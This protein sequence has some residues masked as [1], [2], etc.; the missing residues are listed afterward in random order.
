MTDNFSIIALND[1]LKIILNQYK[2]NSSVFGIPQQ[3]FFIPDNNLTIGIKKFGRELETPIGIA[4]GPQSQL[5]QNIV[6]AWLCGA[7]FIELKTVQTLDELKVSKP[8]I[9]MQDEGYNCEWSQELKLHQSFD[10]YLN[11]WIIIHVLRD[12]FGWNNSKQEATIFNMSVGYDYN[13]ILEENIQWFFRKMNNATGELNEKIE[14]LKNIYPN[15]VNLKINP[16]ISNNITLSTMHG[17]PPEEIEKIG[18]YLIC[19]KKLHTSIKLNPTLLGKESL[20]KI[21]VN[22]GFETEVPDEAFEHDLKFKDAIKIIKRLQEKAN[23]KNLEFG[24]KLT[25]TLESRNNKKVFPSSEKMMYMSGR[26]LHPISIVLANKLQTEFD[27]NLNISFSGGADAFNIDNILNSGLMPVTVCTDLLKPG[28]YSRLKQYIDVI[29]TEYLFG[30]TKK[31]QLSFLNKYAETAKK[32]NNYKKTDLRNPSI[33]TNR[34]LEQFDCINA[35]CVDTC[36]TNQGIP[37]YLYYTSK[38]EFEKAMEIIEQTNPFPNTTGMVCDHLCQTKCTRINY[39]SPV[40]IREIKRFVSEKNRLSDARIQEK[41]NHKN[42]KSV[43]IIGAGPSGLSCANYLSN[44]G[45]KVDVFEEKDEVGGMVSAAIPSF[46]L[47]NEAMYIDINKIKEKGVK[48]HF[49][50]KITKKKFQQLREKND[51][52]YLAVGAQKSSSLNIDGINNNAVLDPLQFLFNVKKEKITNLGTNVIIIGGGNTAMDAARTAFRLVEKTGSVSIVY[53]RKI[54]QMPADLGEIEA[55]IEEGIKIYELSSPLKIEF[56]NNKLTGIICQKMKL[57]EKDESGR[58]KPIAIPNSE[59]TITA[60]TIIPAIGQELNI[61]FTKFEN[62]KT[63]ANSF[64]TKLENVF[65][66]GD[67]YRGAS[68]AINAIGD[69]RKVAQEI[70]NKAKINFKTKHEYQRF[71]QSKLQLMLQKFNRAKA[72][73]ITETSLDDRKNFN[74]VSTSL[75]EEQAIREASRCLMCDEICNICTTVC[76]NLAFHS[77]KIDPKKYALQKIVADKNGFKT[78]NSQSKEIK[79]KYQILHL[80]DWC[81]QC[82]NCNT[83]CPTSEA[84]YK[85]KPHLYFDKKLFETQKDGYYLNQKNDDPELNFYENN[86][87]WK[88]SNKGDHLRLET[89]KTIVDFELENLQIIKIK[90]EILLEEDF[91]WLAEKY[92]ILQGALSFYSI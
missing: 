26:A 86:K 47:T 60:D 73:T 10:Q 83:F 81:N 53:R 12:Y 41:T 71:K 9:D 89:N 77:Y 16:Q 64:E 57:A 24:I 44:A 67:A 84:P 48:I 66:G 25:N 34:K 19:E 61:D 88:L 7:R 76:P 45:F 59:F 91:N 87:L 33:K 58:A 3:Q 40:L 15:I 20:N 46:R 79:Q 38:G 6:A 92:Y 31:N 90:N 56:N 65:I 51:F 32:N 11:A 70:I 50:L 62:L 74:L 72:E 49:N 52:V 42:N 21:L 5:T 37:D 75:T 28:G 22:S 30:E 35:P 68:T 2:Q 80:A 54:K 63:K 78:V 17:C 14:S 55:V 82:G 69:G 43:A 36:P 8:C 18:E 13:G 29:E 23:N 85:E 1:L 39:D 4:A 27:G